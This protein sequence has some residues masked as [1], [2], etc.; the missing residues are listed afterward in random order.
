MSAAEVEFLTIEG[1][2]CPDDV[3]PA[4]F[5]FRCVNGNKGRHAL[6]PTVRCACLLI[7]GPHAAPHGVKRDPNN[8]NDGRAQW[9]WDGNRAAPTFKPSVNCSSHCGWHG[10][11]RNGR[12]V[13]TAG[14]DEA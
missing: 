7:A 10:Y 3:K 8:A 2:A 11:I 1:E 9:D 12:A 6:L 4:R 5:T 13:D 14:K